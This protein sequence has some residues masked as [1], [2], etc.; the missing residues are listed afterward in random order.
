MPANRTKVKQVIKDEIKFVKKD[1]YLEVE[2]ASRG[3]TG[4]PIHI[5][6]PGNFS[7]HIEAAINSCMVLWSIESIKLNN[8]ND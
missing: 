8:G 7:S 2:K 4:A 5:R 1:L 6:I 3:K